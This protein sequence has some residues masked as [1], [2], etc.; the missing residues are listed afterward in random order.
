MSQAIFEAYW[1]EH[2]RVLERLPALFPEL[3]R[4]SEACIRALEQGGK[5]MVCGN[6]GSAADAQHFAAELSGRYRRERRP[7]AAL[8]L[9]TDSSALTC[10]GNDYAFEQVFARQLEALARPGDVLFGIST[11][12]RSKNVLAALEAAARLG[13]VRVGLTGEHTEAM[14]PLTDFCLAVPSASTA[15]VQEMHVLLIHMIC[16]ALDGWALGE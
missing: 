9:T 7:L 3:G 2:R 5:L 15:R 6:G 11:S 10:I 16:E 1:D 4:V 14:R 12:G 13:V 8:A